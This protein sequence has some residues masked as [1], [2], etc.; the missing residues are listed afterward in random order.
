MESLRRTTVQEPVER[1]ARLEELELHYDRLIA[2]GQH[3]LAG[4]ASASP[5]HP[6]NTAGF[7]SYADGVK[8]LRVE[9]M[10]ANWELF[11]QE[12]VE[13]IC[14]PGLKLRVLFANVHEACGENDPQSRSRKGA[15]SERVACGDLFERAG[16]D[17]PDAVVRF[18]G[19]YKTYYLMVDQ[20]GAMELSLP[21][22]KAG[23]NFSHCV[24]R[25]FL[26]EGSELDEIDLGTDEPAD[27]SDLDFVVTRK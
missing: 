21:I 4:R 19:D 14:N 9:N 12:G 6:S 3:A 26:T 17:L 11:S 15:G 2:A 13:G 18:R 16:I 5:L 27:D 8:G 23:G 20:R 25:I 1:N 24:E 22:V 10:D 7:L